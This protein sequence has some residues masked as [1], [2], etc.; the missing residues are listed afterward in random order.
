MANLFDVYFSKSK[1]IIV[2]VLNGGEGSLQVDGEPMVK[3][4][5]SSRSGAAEKHTPVIEKTDKGFRV[6]VGSLTHSMDANHWTQWIELVVDD[7]K[8]Y[9]QVLKPGDPSEATFEVSDA[10]KVVARAFC[11]LH[12]LWEAEYKG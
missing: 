10:K 4:D 2:E 8:I 3:L 6:K 11:N 1:G 7:N 9:R 5:E 12:G